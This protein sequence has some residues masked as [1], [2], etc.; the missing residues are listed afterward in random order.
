MKFAFLKSHGHR[1]AWLLS[2]V[3]V[4]LAGGITSAACPSLTVTLVENFQDDL[5][6]V[7]NSSIESRILGLKEELAK[8]LRVLG[9]R[10][11]DV[12][13]LRSELQILERYVSQPVDDILSKIIELEIELAKS[14]LEFSGNHPEVKSLRKQI[15][16]WRQFANRERVGS[17][18][19]LRLDMQLENLRIELLDLQ[20][21][22][23]AAGHPAIKKARQ[24]MLRLQQDRNV[25]GLQE[26]CERQGLYIW[27]SE[28]D[29]LIAAEAKKQGLS[30]VEW[31][32]QKT[33]D[34]GQSTE[35]FRTN[36]V[37]KQ[38]ALQKL[39]NSKTPLTDKQLKG[40]ID[41]FRQRQ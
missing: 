39:A 28:I 31:L 3:A 24:E 38:L 5:A 29:R 16:R 33:K 35:E 36:V 4:L 18:E 20:D 40:V 15:Y 19:L 8:Q 30:S 34:F 23:F 27:A 12:L 32:K 11:P 14:Q 1:W 37:W 22:N 25:L 2:S 13:E 41:R 9:S 26:E 21:S 7:S 10:H 17:E 6:P